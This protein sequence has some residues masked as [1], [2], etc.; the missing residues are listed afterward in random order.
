MHCSVALYFRRW[1]V[2]LWKEFYDSFLNIP[3]AWELSNLQVWRERLE[4]YLLD[5]LH[6]HVKEWNAEVEK[7]AHILGRMSL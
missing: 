5:W 1:N 3:N 6:N 4:Q 2:E 7:F